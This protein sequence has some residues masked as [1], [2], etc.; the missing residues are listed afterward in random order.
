[1]RKLFFHL[2]KFNSENDKLFD[3]INQKEKNEMK[4]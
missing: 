2:N 1:M 4:Y 3:L